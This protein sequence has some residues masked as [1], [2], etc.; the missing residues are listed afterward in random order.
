MFD[1]ILTFIIT[2]LSANATPY[3]T[4]FNPNPEY[5]V[6]IITQNYSWFFPF[7]T[8]V[9]F[10]ITDYILAS[11]T[12]LDTRNLLLG[13]AIAYTM[14]SYLE[15]TGGLTNSVWFFV[16]EFIFI[17]ILFLS[18]LFQSNTP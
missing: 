17:L 15:V 5:F 11:K 3:N 6:N 18:Q 16:F 12:Q 7:I 4:T 2:N 14:L 1:I 9:A 10:L 13:T 8:I